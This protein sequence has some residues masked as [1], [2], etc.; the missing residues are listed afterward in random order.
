MKFQ[1]TIISALFSTTLF[2]PNAYSQD[3]NTALCETLTSGY[4]KNQPNS[5]VLENIRAKMLEIG[6]EIPGGSSG[7]VQELLG[8]NKAL[9]DKNAALTAQVAEQ[10]VR[11]KELEASATPSPDPQTCTSDAL[12]KT[13]QTQ[14]S[15]SQAQSQGLTDRLVRCTVSSDARQDRIFELE[16]TLAKQSAELDRTQAAL[17]ALQ[18]RFELQQQVTQEKILA[19][20]NDTLGSMAT[21]QC[22]WPTLSFPENGV[23][24]L[25][26]EIANEQDRKVLVDLIE[27]A[28]LVARDTLV[29][30]ADADACMEPFGTYRVRVKTD[31]GLI[32]R[33]FVQARADQVNLPESEECAQL[34]QTFLSAEVTVKFRDLVSPEKWGFWVQGQRQPEACVYDGA[35]FTRMFRGIS[36]LELVS[37]NK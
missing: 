8:Q 14:L 28:G 17:V 35:G 2:V 18:E 15:E 30:N 19:L 25:S 24:G 33:S 9:L 37:V 1:S 32:K 22:N 27:K 29:I 6:C 10:Q 26:G 36:D 23:A 3:N 4:L 7:E 16:G 13:L 34:G 12:V 5:A 20:F 11:I 31:G 21:A